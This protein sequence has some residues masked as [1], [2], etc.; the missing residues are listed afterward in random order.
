MAKSLVRRAFVDVPHEM[1]NSDYAQKLRSI[2]PKCR[3]SS[4]SILGDV[5][6]RTI[7][8]ININDLSVES[9]AD[10][11]LTTMIVDKG[12]SVLIDRFI[13]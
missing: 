13:F 12:R 8:N 2:T 1:C 7:G 6:G 11:D 9:A 3:R 4:Y 5:Q 10:R